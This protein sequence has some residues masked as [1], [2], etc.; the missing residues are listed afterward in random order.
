MKTLKFKHSSKEYVYEIKSYEID[1]EEKVLTVKVID[2]KDR[3]FS[4]IKN[5]K[6]GGA[7]EYVVDMSITDHD[8]TGC[9]LKKLA[10]T[11]NDEYEI[12]IE[13]EG[14]EHKDVNVSRG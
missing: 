7:K 5:N 6:D 1:F 12:T 8:F 3:L 13:Y 9:K 4:W 2:S 14:V 11:G 10:Y